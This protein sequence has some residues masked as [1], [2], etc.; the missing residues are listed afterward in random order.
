MSEHCPQCGHSSVETDIVV[1]ET[2]KVPRYACD[3]SG[4][5]VVTYR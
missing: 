5:P 4:C 3:T 1:M 2:A